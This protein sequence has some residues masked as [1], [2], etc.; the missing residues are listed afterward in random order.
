MSYQSL[1][2]DTPAKE[3]AGFRVYTLEE[4]G[5]TND[6][7]LKLAKLGAPDGVALSALK[8]RKGRG[9]LD[10]TWLGK[11][12]QSLALSVLL[13]PTKEEQAHLLRFTALAGLALLE[14]LK[15]RY[16]LQT[17]LKWPN[18]VLLDGAKVCGILT[19][20]LW[21]GNQADAVVI[22]IGVNLGKEAYQGQQNLRY[23][24]ISLEE[25]LGYLVSIEELRDALLES[26]QNL[27]PGMIQEDFIFSWN[28][29]LAFVGER[30]QILNEKGETEWFRLKGVQSNG[31]LLVEDM[32]GQLRQLYSSEIAP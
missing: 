12:G 1:L 3:V 29:N 18:D 8:Q 14:V 27:R 2:K 15:T 26:I 22:G 25:H 11:P 4:T 17:M 5:S 32:S 13:R 23:K 7:L 10:R 21:N 16:G 19:E 6:D 24:A 9:R 31:A 28:R 30:V 20:S